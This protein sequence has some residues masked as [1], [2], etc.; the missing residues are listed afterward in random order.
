MKP[1][2][3]SFIFLI[4]VP[5][6]KF[7]SVLLPI[8]LS[9]L[10]FLTASIPS[11][12]QLGQGGDVQVI[13]LEGIAWRDV[14]FIQEAVTEV[15]ICQLKPGE[16]FNIQ[17]VQM[18]GC[19]PLLELPA[20]G[21]K[22]Q[23]ALNFIA[24]ASCQTV[25]VHVDD[26]GKGCSGTMYLTT[27]CVTCKEHSSAEQGG[28]RGSLS[29]IPAMIPQTLVQ[30]IFIG[31]GC[32]DISNVTYKGSYLAEGSFSGGDNS[33]GI[34][35]GV[36]LSS[37][38][39]T[40]AI[41][42]NNQTGAGGAVGGGSDIDLVAAMG[43]GSGGVI[44]DACKLE[45]DFV[46]T[47]S[48][49][50]FRYVFA[51][52]EYCDYVNSTFNDVFGFFIS[53]PGISGPYSNNAM[54][55]AVLPG[56]GVGGTPVSIN[57]VN[58]ITNSAYYVGNIPAGDPQLS[59]PNCQ[60]H[61]IAGPPSTLACQY[62]GF[63]KVLTAV[64][65][66][67]PCETYHIKLA[68]GDATDDAFDSAVFLGANS[69]N[70]GGNA[71]V[72]ATVPP[73]MGTVAYEGCNNGY[74]T[75]TRGSGDPTVPLV[76]NFTVSGTA[77]VGQDYAPIPLSVT[78][79]A[80][81]SFV[82][83][84]VTI[85]DDVIAEGT[86]T[87]IITLENPCNCTTSTAIMEIVDPTPVNVDIDIDP[88]C[89][90]NPFTIT[91]TITGGAPPYQ[92]AWSPSGSGAIYN[93]IANLPGV[94]TV[95]V[96]D[97]C[98]SV[99]TD[100]ANLEVYTLKA[101]ISG[102]T[103]VC[104][105]SPGALTVTFTGIGP[106]SFT[107]QVSGGGP[108]TISGITQNPYQLAAPVP[109]TYTI[110]SVNNGSCSGPGAGQGVATIPIIS[111]S[112]QVTN[113]AC[114]GGSTGAIDLTVN[115]GTSP[116]TYAWNYNSTSQ[117]LQNIPAGFYVV[118]VIDNRGCNMVTSALVS[119]PPLL[120]ATAN[121]LSGVNCDNPEGGSINL[122]VAGGT[123]G[124][125]Y[126]WNTGGNTE[127]LTG[128]TAGT[129]IVTVTDSHNCTATDTVAVLGD[130]SI[131]IAE[132][133]VIG[134][135]N[136]TNNILTL[137]ASASTAG[138]NYTYEWLA[139]GGG[140]ITG[141]I[142]AAITTA[143]GAGTYVLT[144]SDTL[145]NCFTEAS[146]VVQA[147]FSTP[148]AAAGPSQV[149]DCLTSE[150]MLDGTGSTP[151]PGIA[152]TWTTSGGNF[153]SPTNIPTPTVDAPGDYVL[154]VTNTANGCADT[155]LVSVA[156]D[157]VDP[158]ADAGQDGIIDCDFTTYQL[159]GTGSS[160]GPGFTYLWTTSDGNIVDDPTFFNP[161]TDQAGIYILLVTDTSNGCTATD[162][163]V[164]S[165]LSTDPVIQIEAP[166]VV[167]CSQ[168]EISLDASGSDSGAGIVFNWTGI[169]GGTIISGGD[170]PTPVVGSSGTYE[171]TL[172]NTLTGC[173]S[174]GV[175][176]VTDDLIQP[177]AD[178]G[179]PLTISCSLPDLQLDGTGSSSGPGYSYSW[180]VTNG[181]N[182]VA[183]ANTTTPT[184]NNSG[185][186]ILTVT[187]LTNGCFAV[188]SVEVALDTDAPMAVASTPQILDC[189]HPEVLVSG[190]GSSLGANFNYE[191]TTTDGNIVLG[192]GTLFLTANEPGT[193]TLT[194]TNSLNSCSSETSVVLGI[195]TL[196]P[197][198]QIAPSGM[199]TCAVPSLQLD[200]GNSSQGTGFSYLWTT[201][202]GSIIGDSTILNPEV[203]QPGL[204]NL[205][206]TNTD[207]GCTSET[208]IEVFQDLV[209][210]AAEAGN[211]AELNCGISS[212]VLDG[213][214]SASGPEFTYSWT[215]SN[216]NIVSG[217][218][219]LM[220][221]IDMPG[222]Y[223]ITVLNS[224]NGCTASDQV[225]IT[226][227]LSSPQA[228][229]G[230][231]GVLTC[232]STSLVLNGGGSS[233]SGN[234][235]FAW[236]TANGNIVGS[237]DITMPMI[238]QAGDYQ[239]IV[240]QTDNLCTDTATV[241]VVQ[242]TL[243]PVA[244]AGPTLELD[245]DVT[246]LT[247]N[248][249]GSSTGPAFAY[250]WSTPDGII[251]AGGNTLTPT[252]N[253]S[254]TY[255]LTVLDNSNGC[256]SLDQVVITQD[257]NTP[258]ADAG[259]TQQLN[260]LVSTLVLD[261]N[262][263]S[264]G[265]G[266]TYQWTTSG[267]NFLSGDTGLNPT[268]DAPGT[269]VLTV[270]NT[271]NNCQ[272]SSAVTI[273]QDIVAPVAEAGA[274]AVLTCFDPSISLNADASS[275]G[276]NFSYAWSTAGGNIVSGANTLT[277]QVDQTGTYTLVVTNTTN[278][279]TSTDATTVTVDQTPPAVVLS[280]PGQLTCLLPSLS[281]SASGT[282]TGPN[283]SYLWTTADGQ[284]VAGATTLSPTVDEPGTYTLTVTNNQ[285]GCTASQSVQVTQSE[286]PPDAVAGP[287][288]QLNCSVST[289]QLNGAGSSFG[290]NISYQ[291]VAGNGG[292]IDNGATSLSP[293]VS[294]PGVYTLTVLNGLNGC[295]ST[296]SVVISEDVEVP[297]VAIGAP[298]VLTCLAEEI[299]LNA[300]GSDSGPGFQLTWSATGGGNIVNTSNLLQPLVDAPGSYT[301]TI[302]N[303]NNTCSASLTVE[304]LEMVDPPG[305]SAGPDLLLHC[306]QQALQLQ[307]SSPIGS[308]GVY[309]WTTVDGA[310]LG[311]ANTPQPS[312]SAPGAYVLTVTDP[313][314]GCTSADQMIVTADFPVSMDY[315]VDP[316]ACLGD[317]GY[318]QF[319]DVLGGTPPYQYSISGGFTFSGQ[320]FYGALDAGTYDLV[321][322]DANGC[323]LYDEAFLAPGVDV[324]LDVE[325]EVLLSLGESYAVQVFVNIDENDIET[326][327]WEP[328]L[329][330]SCNDCLTPIVTP[331]H[332]IDYLVTVTTAEGCEGEVRLSFRVKKQAD[333]YVPNIF[334]PNGDGENDIF[335]IFAGSQIAEVKNFEVFNRWGESVFQ[336]FNFHPN[337]PAFG[338][339][340]KHRGQEVNPS[341]YTWYAEIEMIDGRIELFEGSVALIR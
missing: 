98:G 205:L 235:T 144:V 299:P 77:T 236:S 192:E 324:E 102:S 315:V 42:P 314:N 275:Q 159:N 260:C 133:Q 43:Q 2:F 297:V 148:V 46:P 56:S 91:P 108:V 33:V 70:L 268:V 196:A 291:W 186:Y 266:Y 166:G 212:I 287:A 140:A 74:F 155:S 18:D 257:V 31:G 82:Q 311:G 279:C 73:I 280:P 227:N 169:N 162:E 328:S 292:V 12:A 121:A 197:V 129:Y 111:L 263:S 249:T 158:I 16:T 301:L 198:A 38:P 258:V 309:A 298:A 47:V 242:N 100:T 181:G 27:V 112:T 234:L 319:G 7:K 14:V 6:M 25:Y 327:T 221:V 213:A 289:L 228:L 23:S 246:S 92:Y 284:I 300:L 172:T 238:D 256:T 114:F 59:N 64:A 173:Q 147:D 288:G 24:G 51:S 58:H 208:E 247:L 101:T 194:V 321:V 187:D 67:I 336:Y 278:G 88:I 241:T 94:Y 331:T 316:P 9:S 93:G 245:C 96:T 276:A 180:A 89:K 11:T 185:I 293:T 176:D 265:P 285:N 248:G 150:V 338:W 337:D 341:V 232:S 182:L 131:P 204:Y 219:S 225:V 53:G 253:A 251:A 117:D 40:A 296:D 54:N 273:T 120:T 65:N 99:D 60:G 340:G 168:P 306:D 104:P 237:T 217:N 223:L 139:S 313:T 118:N 83:V 127:D 202:D 107:Y 229:I 76:I 294:A 52:E 153:T 224:D 183:G 48:Q 193:Y 57:N 215:T 269:Y 21:K 305:A 226:E 178:A 78:I 134:A 28:L 95:T 103:T 152:Y 41:G 210:P 261:G 244:E 175:V 170:T 179:P 274:T 138:P 26:P 1:N 317:P 119:Q 304:V 199:L 333:V 329:F 97:Y 303:L 69:F 85:F 132:F 39:V 188:D 137:D 81:Q 160:T 264:Q 122:D 5:I 44:M 239:L 164:V 142:N 10:F 312:V 151:G 233:G 30:D 325:R 154:V 255:V 156:A 87:I 222:L 106:W 141:N 37:G 189:A 17:A 332:S 254:G 282:S 177:M 123:P 146:L 326:I 32:F 135:I 72:I 143:E 174:V 29:V 271:Q 220:P 3:H 203:N 20:T 270:V 231:P 230:A 125:T 86:E 8:L 335:M 126:S 128:L 113:V 161:T 195:D 207:N 66:V 22:P 277:P 145:N 308:A 200:G 130:S 184:I 281:L 339:D 4:T 295:S 240:T 307:G 201:S 36:I 45:F 116:Y 68:V 211:T 90:G 19:Q 330:L 35:S 79:P 109:G 105:G 124:Y 334:S 55:I 218:T 49:I 206:V 80:N 63:T 323:E 115:G 13:N 286:T 216:G 252:V 320:T 290:A 243:A 163:A 34:P 165:D 250:T 149:I 50:A 322:R 190:I 157:L 267:G 71:E 214:G 191:W 75:F 62:D 302:L 318:I 110:L 15:Q 310:L 283:F 209:P 61:P 272:S 167:T 171:L 136:C 84:P 259:V 262:G